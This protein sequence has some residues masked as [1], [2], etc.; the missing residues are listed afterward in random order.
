MVPLGAVFEIK[1]LFC[2]PL[3][4]THIEIVRPGIFPAAKMC[5]RAPSAPL[6]SNCVSEVLDVYMGINIT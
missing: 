5:A 2:E 4:C 1:V 6:I 3:G